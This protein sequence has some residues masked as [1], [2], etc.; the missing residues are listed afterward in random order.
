MSITHHPTTFDNK[1]D[2]VPG[3]FQIIYMTSGGKDYCRCTCPISVKTFEEA[4][5]WAKENFKRV[6]DSYS[7]KNVTLFTVDRF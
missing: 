5:V 3:D 6:A 7:K 1:L 2:K 4:K